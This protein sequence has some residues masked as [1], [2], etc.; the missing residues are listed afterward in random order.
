MD[1][2]G[3]SSFSNTIQVTVS[4]TPNNF[5]LNQNYPNPFNPTTKISWQS[6][7]SGWQTLKVYDVLGNVVAALVDEFR[8]AGFYEINF[9]ASQLSSGVYIYKLSTV[10][11]TETKKMILSK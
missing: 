10:D 5:S 1:S 8:D 9:D 7:V 2:D 3:G 4:H 11:F 6:P